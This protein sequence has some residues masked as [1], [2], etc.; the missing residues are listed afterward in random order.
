MREEK[1]RFLFLVFKEISFRIDYFLKF[2]RDLKFELI[3]IV[4]IFLG[5]F[6]LTFF[7][8]FMFFFKGCLVELWDDM[9]FVRF[10][11]GWRDGIYKKGFC[12]NLDLVLIK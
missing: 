11:E 3:F 10:G 5:C 8:K 7:S 6:W 12:D 1:V 4:I 9:L 2:S